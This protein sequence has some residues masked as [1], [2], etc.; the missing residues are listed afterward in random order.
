M[1]V[2]GQATGHRVKVCVQAI[3]YRMNM[4][5]QATGHRVKVYVQAIE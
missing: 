1:N 3:E 2:S 4:S 5:G